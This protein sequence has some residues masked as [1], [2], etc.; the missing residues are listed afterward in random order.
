METQCAVHSNEIRRGTRFTTSEAA[1]WVDWKLRGV[2]HTVGNCNKYLIKPELPWIIK[3]HAITHSPY[4]QSRLFAK[5]DA[6]R[7]KNIVIFFD[8]MHRSK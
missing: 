2:A 6:V 7:A 8:R 5:R 4:A 3:R 1:A